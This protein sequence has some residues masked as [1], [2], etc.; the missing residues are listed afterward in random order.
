MDCGMCPPVCGDGTCATSEGPCT[1][2][3]DCGPCVCAHPVCE[4]GPALVGA[5]DPCVAMIC[6]S[7]MFCCSTFWDGLCVSHVA[8]ICGDMCTGPTCGDGICQAT[9]SCTTCPGDC[10]ACPPTCPDVTLASTVPLTVTGTTV[11]AGNDFGMASCSTGA[12]P[13]RSFSYTA[14]M[15]GT[16]TIDTTGVGITYDT[17][18]YVRNGTTCLG[19]ELACNDNGAGIG[20]RSRVT[21]SLVAGQQINIIVDGAGAFTQGSF[22]LNIRLGPPPC[23]DVDLGTTV[24]STT[25]GTTI[26][27]GNDQ[28]GA[29]CGG[30]GGSAPD[31]VFEWT[32]PTT[33]T[34]RFDTV[35]SAATFDT[36]LYIRSGN[37]VGAQ[38][39]C[40][41]DSAGGT[42]SRIDLAM[43]AG[44]TVVV[45]VDGFGVHQG[46][47]TLNITDLTPAMCGDGTCNGTETCMTC[48]ADCGPCAMCTHS[49]CVTGDALDESCDAC[50]AIVCPVDSF[51]CDFSWDFACVFQAET[52]CG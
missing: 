35:G 44:Q 30:G 26:G 7:D 6:A 37:C 27:A 25:T 23:V 31:R 18:L 39:G 4:E 1:C 13:D 8:T 36:L 43:T 41:D 28:G 2:P 29:T 21:L 16:Y 19:P 9:E 50:A 51:C 42:K 15:T 14:P 46:A 17:L 48:A 45:V 32:A 12:G 47:F 49:P 22:T 11:G 5:C 38:L 40:D 33:G 24:P 10:G 52:L 3:A 34:F 20:T